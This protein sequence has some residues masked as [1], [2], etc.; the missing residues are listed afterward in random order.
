MTNILIP[1]LVQVEKNVKIRLDSWFTPT[2]SQD[3][4]NK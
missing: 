3:G 1:N 4:I 2:V